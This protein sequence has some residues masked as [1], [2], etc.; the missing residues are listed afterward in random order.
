MQLNDLLARGRGRDTRQGCP[1]EPLDSTASLALGLHQT[2]GWPSLSLP[3]LLASGPR[4]LPHPAQE[5]VWGTTVGHIDELVSSA[6]WVV[7]SGGSRI[8]H[9]GYNWEVSV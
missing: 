9:M 4:W 1:P 5:Q 7:L 8:S 6:A 2:K 3:A